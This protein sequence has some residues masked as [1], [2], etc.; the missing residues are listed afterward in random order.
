AKK[1]QQLAEQNTA[2]KEEN[3]ALSDRHAVEPTAQRR[4]RAPGADINNNNF[5]V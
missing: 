2:L 3:A 5:Y 4:K 1:R